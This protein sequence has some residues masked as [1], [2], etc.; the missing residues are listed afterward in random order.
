MLKL[1]KKLKTQT[2]LKVIR[3]FYHIFLAKKLKKAQELK[4]FS[5]NN[6]IKPNTFE[7]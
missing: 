4:A 6:K 5:E 1:F 2:V 7:L 3:L